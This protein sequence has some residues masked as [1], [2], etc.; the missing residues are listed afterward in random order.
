MRVTTTTSNNTDTVTAL[1]E[2]VTGSVHLRVT[3]TLGQIWCMC[4]KCDGKADTRNSTHTTL[5]RLAL[6]RLEMTDPWCGG[7]HVH[8]IHS[9]PNHCHYRNLFR[10]THNTQYTATTAGQSP[11]PARLDMCLN[12][13]LNHTTNIDIVVVL[14]SYER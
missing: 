11:H 5:R 2:P 8:T 13:V 3:D 9:K 12:T 7:C 1:S 10:I 4:W 6:G 14:V